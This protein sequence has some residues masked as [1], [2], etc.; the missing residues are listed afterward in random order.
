MFIHF[1]FQTYFLK[2][3]KFFTPSMRPL[4][5]REAPRLGV[6]G[7]LS[8]ALDSSACM[9]AHYDQNVCS[10]IPAID[11]EHDKFNSF[12]RIRQ[13]AQPVPLG[14]CRSSDRK[15]KFWRGTKVW[16]LR[17]DNL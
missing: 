4:S 8:P 6:Q 15:R 3:E 5:I 9:K 13:M 10:P 12:I 2:T 17:T 1:I 7:V 14:C 11:I 16:C